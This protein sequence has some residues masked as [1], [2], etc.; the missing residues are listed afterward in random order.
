MDTYK[1]RLGKR[2][3]PLAYKVRVFMSLVGVTCGNDMPRQL[4]YYVLPFLGFLLIDF[5]RLN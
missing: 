1:F 2:H 5:K 3:V 4:L